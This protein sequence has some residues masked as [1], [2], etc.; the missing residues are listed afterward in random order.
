MAAPIVIRSAA[1]AGALAVGLALGGVGMATAQDR[2]PTVPES[3]VEGMQ[4]ADPLAFQA[5]AAAWNTFFIRASELA[6]ERSAGEDERALAQELVDEHVA[7]VPALA[8]AAEA[9][10]LPTAPVVGLDG[11]QSGMMGR[12]E[13]A[14]DAE[15]DRLYLDMLLTGYDEAYGLFSGYAEN[16]TGNLRAFAAE[17]AAVLDGRRATL[18][19]LIEGTEPS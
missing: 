3:I 6:L 14:P 4:V 10:E 16:G 15:F 1:V 11:R 12:L 17:A 7:L 13:A 9:D 18:T 8:S 19:T 5:T 2:A